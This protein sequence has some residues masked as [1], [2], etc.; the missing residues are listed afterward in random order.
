MRL[1]EADKLRLET[2]D[3][4]TC[5]HSEIGHGDSNGCT[6]WDCEYINKKEALRAYKERMAVVRCKDCK[7]YRRKEFG[8][9]VAHGKYGFGDE[10]YCSDGERIGEIEE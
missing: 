10:S 1:I 6:S 2:R 8:Y 9:C 7:K 3:C 4:K 5:I